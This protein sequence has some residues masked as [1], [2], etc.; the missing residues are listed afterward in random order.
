M[1]V[2]P[3]KKDISV[4]GRGVRDVIWD[5]IDEYHLVERYLRMLCG[6][7]NKVEVDAWFAWVAD[8]HE[9]AER[10]RSWSKKGQMEYKYGYVIR[11][12]MRG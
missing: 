10:N 9:D 4:D 5:S 6:D 8:D 7:M 12:I 1:S 11:T 2:L 3:F